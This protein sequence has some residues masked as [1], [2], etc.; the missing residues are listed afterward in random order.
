MG[1]YGVLIYN[2]IPTCSQITLNEERRVYKLY[3]QMNNQLYAQLYE[4]LLNQLDIQL[5]NQLQVKTIK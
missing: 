5:V 1:E 3:I 4:Q 2:N